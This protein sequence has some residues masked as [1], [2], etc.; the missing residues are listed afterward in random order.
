[1]I[2]GI[3]NSLPTS[4]LAHSLLKCVSAVYEPLQHTHTDILHT[5]LHL[6]YQK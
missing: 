4:A 1:M 3:T 6:I 5:H 2:I